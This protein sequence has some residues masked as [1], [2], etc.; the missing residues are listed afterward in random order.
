MNATDGKQGGVRS[1]MEDDTNESNEP[2]WAA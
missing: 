1:A 2:V